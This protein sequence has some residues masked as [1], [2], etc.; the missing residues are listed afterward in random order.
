M[1]NDPEDVEAMWAAIHRGKVD[2]DHRRAEYARNRTKQFPIHLVMIDELNMF[3][4]LTLEAWAAKLAENKRL[5]KE[6]Q[7]DLPKECPVWADIRAMLHMGRFV[8]IHVI[9]VAQDFRAEILGGHGARN[10]FGLRGMGGF[11]P[12]QWKMFIGT[13]PVPAAQRGVGRWIFWQG[14]QQDWVQIT[15]CDRDAAYAFA[16]HGREL[17][18]ERAALG[19]ET[20]QPELTVG[21]DTDLDYTAPILTESTTSSDKD[22]RRIIVGVKEAARYLG[23]SKWRTFDT[24]RSRRPIPGQFDQGRNVAWY[25]DDLDAWYR[26]RNRRKEDHDG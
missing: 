2:M 5:P 1:A 4:E 6:D 10:G 23:Y 19:Y 9:C 18:D 20:E 12:S 15:K 26:A 24:A 22:T 3:K 7:E 11:L 21:S 25:A 14:E 17:H 8:G 13:T 16:A